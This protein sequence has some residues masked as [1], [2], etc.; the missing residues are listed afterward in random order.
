M[1]A[2]V[3]VTTFSCFKS[4]SAKNN[5]KV[6]RNSE[7]LLNV[8]TVLA[9]I[10]R[11]RFLYY[12]ISTW[13]KSFAKSN[14]TCLVRSDIIN[15]RSCISVLEYLEKSTAYIVF[16]LI[17]LCNTYPAL[18]ILV[19]NVYDSS[20]WRINIDLF[21]RAGV[22]FFIA[23]TIAVYSNVYLKR[24]IPYRLAVSNGALVENIFSVSITLYDNDIT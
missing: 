24:N 17:D 8:F 14:R 6:I 21:P 16:V 22:N 7:V 3:K 1:L 20:A 23:E 18:V 9:A 5:C 12:I 10:I 11:S 13:S 2:A 19:Y 4:S 15:V